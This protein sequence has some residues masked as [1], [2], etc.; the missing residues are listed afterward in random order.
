MKVA[1]FFAVLVLS[2]F[3]AVPPSF[4]RPAAGSS[5]LVKEFYAQLVGTMKQGEKLGFPGRYKRLEPVIKASYNMPLMTKVAV[6]PTWSA[7][8]EA[9]R[10]R[11]IDAFTAFSVA[12]YASRFTKF[13]GENFE[14]LG[15]KPSSGGG[16][17]VETRLTP[18]D[19]APVALHYVIRSDE[20]KKPRI[21]D[22][23]LDASISELATRRAEFS[24][25]IKRDGMEALIGMLN[26]KAKKIGLR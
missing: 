13:D 16:I 5:A 6:G 24:A 21:V 22:V 20:Q 26:E 19:S 9:D 8:K 23:L 14:V 3:F 15:E 18:K 7:M 2:V 10:R 11:L 12:T 4:A 17:I 25:I 1:R